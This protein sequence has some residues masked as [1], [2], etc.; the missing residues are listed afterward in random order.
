M[1][2]RRGYPV[3][4]TILYEGS[5]ESSVLQGMGDGRGGE[6]AEGERGG[7]TGQEV[8]EG[9]GGL[10]GKEMLERL[11]GRALGVIGAEKTGDGVGNFVGA[12]TIA[13]GSGDGGELAY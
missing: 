12:A 4:M 7:A 10:C 8:A 6:V 9:V 2:Q 3:G 5:R 1:P 11:L 13:Y